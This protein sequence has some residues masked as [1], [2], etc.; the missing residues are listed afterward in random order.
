MPSQAQGPLLPSGAALPGEG[1]VTAPLV[2]QCRFSTAVRNSPS[3]YE[4]LIHLSSAF[5]VFNISLS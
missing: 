1:A 3:G 5:S 4:K 2:T